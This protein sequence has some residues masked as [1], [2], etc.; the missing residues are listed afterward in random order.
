MDKIK[1]CI[2]HINEIFDTEDL[3]TNVD[4]GT[5][6]VVSGSLTQPCDLVDQDEEHITDP[7]DLNKHI[8]P[9]YQL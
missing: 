8:Y 5:L 3:A 4:F 6:K 7:L 1:I 2:N 9:L